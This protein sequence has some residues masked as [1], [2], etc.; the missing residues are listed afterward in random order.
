MR[1]KYLDRKDYKT[2]E[3]GHESEMV[4][5][6]GYRREVLVKTAYFVASDGENGGGSPRQ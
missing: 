2:L 5:E 1:E 6:Y 4:S 3:S